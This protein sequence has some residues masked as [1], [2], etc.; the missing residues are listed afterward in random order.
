MYSFISDI[1]DTLTKEE[2]QIKRRAK[3]QI[4]GIL[5]NPLNWFV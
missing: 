4:N 5:L 3:T 2:L 1:T